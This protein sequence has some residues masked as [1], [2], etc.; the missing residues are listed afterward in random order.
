[1]EAA[2]ATLWF[3]VTGGGGGGGGATPLFL[4]LSVEQLAS[5]AAAAIAATVRPRVMKAL[6]MEA[7]PRTRGAGGSAD[8]ERRI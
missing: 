7:R 4:E 8:T 3:S 5:K 1:M 2:S 6:G